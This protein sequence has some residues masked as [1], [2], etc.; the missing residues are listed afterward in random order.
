MKKTILFLVFL[1]TAV[2]ADAQKF[3][4]YSHKILSVEGCEVS[5]SVV[6]QGSEYY[7]VTSVSSE[8]LVLVENPIMMIRTFEDEV[9]TLNGSLVNNSSKTSNINIGGNV[10]HITHLVSIAQ[11]AVT[12]EQFQMLRHGIAK[13]RLTMAPINHE[14]TFKKDEIGVELYRLYLKEKADAENF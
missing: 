12:P 13:I 3:V 10:A 14:K 2:F 11:F 9:L 8:R 4:S 6:N 1:L 7:V 5:F